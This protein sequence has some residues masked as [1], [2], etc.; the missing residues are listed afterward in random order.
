MWKSHIYIPREANIFV[1][2][3]LNNDKNQRIF[4]NSQNT[5]L[6]TKSRVNKTKQPPKKPTEYIL[7]YS[8]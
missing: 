3:K 2:N 6:P 5:V 7:K 8:L 4:K 1:I